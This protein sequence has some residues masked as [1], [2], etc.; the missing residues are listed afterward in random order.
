MS[1]WLLNLLSFVF[2]KFWV[3]GVPEDL[4]A[5]VAQVLKDRCAGAVEQK[6]KDLTKRPELSADLQSLSVYFF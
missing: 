3:S 2:S 6:I 5:K 1:F 4:K